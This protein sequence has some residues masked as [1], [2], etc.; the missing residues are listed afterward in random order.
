LVKDR[1]SGQSGLA[2]RWKFA[3]GVVLQSIPGGFKA[4]SQRSG[5]CLRTSTWIMTRSYNPPEEFRDKTA[6]FLAELGSVPVDAIVSPAFRSLAV[7]PY[8]AFEG[9]GAGPFELTISPE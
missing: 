2:T 5:I 6:P 8:L 3:P 9:A 4:A 1:F 7:A